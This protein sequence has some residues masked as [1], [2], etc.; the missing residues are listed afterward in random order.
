MMI[1]IFWEMIIIINVLFT[2]LHHEALTTSYEKSTFP[3]PTALILLLSW[4]G[5]SFYN[6]FCRCLLFNSCIT[7]NIELWVSMYVSFISNLSLLVLYICGIS[8][9]CSDISFVSVFK[10]FLVLVIL[11]YACPVFNICFEYLEL[12]LLF[13]TACIC[14]LYLVWNVRS[15]CPRHFSVQPYISFRISHLRTHLFAGEALLGFVLCFL[16]GMQSLYLFHVISFL[17][18]P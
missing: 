4:T 1:I 14:S 7:S 5:S 13:L 10:T 16:F 9:V 2:I 3:V 12:P 8:L 11:P 18:F 15:V 17:S 6:V